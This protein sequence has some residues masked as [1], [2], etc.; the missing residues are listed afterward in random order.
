[1][2]IYLKS[3]YLYSLGGSYVNVPDTIYTKY[4]HNAHGHPNRRQEM[5]KALPAFD[6]D[7]L[8][9]RATYRIHIVS[10]QVW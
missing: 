3:D 10:E 5:K 9:S 1:M 2:L 6:L 7:N 4:M 8:P